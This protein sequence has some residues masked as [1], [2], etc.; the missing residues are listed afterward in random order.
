[1][2]TPRAVLTATETDFRVQSWEP[3]DFTLRYVDGVFAPENPQ[4]ADLYRERGRC[5]MVVDETVHEIYGDRMRAYFDHHGI[6]LTTIALTIAETA[7]S[8]RTLERIVDGFAE[9]GLLRT[10]PVL[11]VGGGL[12]TDVTGFACASYKR[13]T[14]YVRIPTTL[15]GLIDASVAMKVAVNHGKHKNRLGAFH[16]SREVLL[17]FSFLGTL[18]EPQVRN[19]MA[20]LVKIATVANAGLF[21]LLEKYGEDLLATGFGHRD[22]GPELREVAHR[23]TYDA[24]RTMLELEHTNLHELDLDR[25]IAYGHTWSPTLELAPPTPMLHGHAIS[26][27]MAFSAT[28]A[29]RRGLLTQGERD[30]VHTLFSGLGLSVDSPYLTP[31][32]L[33]AATASIVQTRGGLLRAAVP[34]PIGTCVFLNDVTSEELHETLAA[35]REIVA[36]YP[37]ATEGVA[38]WSR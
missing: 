10:E 36:G 38:M 34:H 26:V 3:I 29:E 8:L 18:P 27:D 22:G 20:E 13:G 14:P 1:M 7:K 9:F 5:L 6:A 19:G 11:V 17:D 23:G 32:L 2:T 16:A 12:T 28:L 25:V 15:I 37:T 24:I 35:H 31:E 33:D 21:D 4:L 30:R